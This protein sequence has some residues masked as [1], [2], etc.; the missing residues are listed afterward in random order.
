MHKHSLITQTSTKNTTS[1]VKN[2]FQSKLQDFTSFKGLEQLSSSSC[3]QVMAIYIMG[4][5]HPRLAFVG[6]ETFTNFCFFGHNFGS[7]YARKP[8][9]GSEGLDDS[10]V[11]KKNLSQKIGSLDW[12][13]GPG[14]F[15]QENAKTPPLVTYPHRTPNQYLKTCFY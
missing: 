4:V 10:L 13:P 8:T 3:W 14:K 7:W 9:K 2:S 15:G 12:R 6:V 1:Q 5:I 11:F